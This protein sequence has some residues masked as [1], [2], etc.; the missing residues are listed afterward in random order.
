MQGNKKHIFK[1]ALIIMMLFFVCVPC[2]LKREIKE[3]LHITVSSLEDFQKPK[4]SFICT[5]FTQTENREY[6]ASL[7]K[8]QK[9]DLQNTNTYFSAISYKTPSVEHTHFYLSNSTFVA[10]VP[11]YIFHQ[12][13][14]I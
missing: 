3:L 7:Q 12:Q 9:K 4:T 10:A 14:R 5:H 1:N 6:S 13:Y 2:S 8:K 11:I